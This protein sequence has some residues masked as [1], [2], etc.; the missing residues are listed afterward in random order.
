[1]RVA[2]LDP[3]RGLER[4]VEG[5]LWSVGRSVRGPAAPWYAVCGS[6]VPTG[7]RRR[8]SGVL[9]TG[10]LGAVWVGG[11]R[12]PTGATT[13]QL[14]LLPSGRP[15]GT[16]PHRCYFW[17][18]LTAAIC[19]WDL[20]ARGLR[21]SSGRDPPA[22]GGALHHGQPVSTQDWRCTVSWGAVPDGPQRSRQGLRTLSALLPGPCKLGC[23]VWRSTPWVRAMR[24]SPV[25]PPL[26]ATREH[27]M[28]GHKMLV[29][30]RA[31]RVCCS[32]TR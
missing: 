17:Y 27:S 13:C 23:V 21:T 3:Y 30:G 6:R 8:P 4:G 18:R 20:A 26:S 11:T 12:S 1:M 9:G 19:F 5:V 16:I 7:P 31:Q 32:G 15:T 10:S 24:A 28:V 22:T 25:R 2:R 14:G 29:V